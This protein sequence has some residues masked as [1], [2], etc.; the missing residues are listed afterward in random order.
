MNKAETD[1]E[2]RPGLEFVAKGVG[3]HVYRVL[4]V[5][6]T[7]CTIERMTKPKGVCRNFRK[8]SVLS[9]IDHVLEE[10]TCTREQ[11]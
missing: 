11:T 7:H 4:E 1:I 5:G 9:A 2:L 10:E 6:R 3:L 8:S